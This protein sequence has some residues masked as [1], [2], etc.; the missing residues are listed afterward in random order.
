MVKD[1]LHDI[2]SIILS[3]ILGERKKRLAIQL[4]GYKE[5]ML[6]Y[7]DNINE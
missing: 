2:R 3:K 6:L 1:L 4:K 7:E 5:A